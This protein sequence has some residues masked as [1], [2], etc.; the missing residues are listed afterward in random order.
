M[1]EFERVFLGGDGAQR[2]LRDRRGKGDVLRLRSWRFHRRV[3]GIEFVQKGVE[4]IILI[5]I[6]RRDR[7]LGWGRRRRHHGLR[8]L[9]FRLELL[10]EVSQRINLLVITIITEAR[11]RLV[12]RWSD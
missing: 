6:S 4:V 10:K 8:H 5:I 12:R 7:I 9:S 3:I 11:L 2:R 1:V